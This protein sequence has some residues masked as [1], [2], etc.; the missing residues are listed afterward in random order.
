MKNIL[1]F[2]HKLSG[3][4]AEKTVVNLVEYINHNYDNIHAY[5]GVVYDDKVIHEKMDCVYVLKSHTT[6]EMSKLRKLPVVLSQAVQ[7]R[8][9]KKQLKIDVCISFLPG[10]DFLN[11]L[12]K[13]KEKIIVSVRNKES[14][15]V[16]N[17]LKKWYIQFCYARSNKIIAISAGVQQDIEE[18]FSAPK[19]K[20]KVIYNP[21]PVKV[22][23]GEL[24]EKY[25]KLLHTKQIVISAGRLTEQK[26]QK[27]LIRAFKTVADINPK[28]HLVILGEGEL[29]TELEQEIRRLQLEERIT[30]MGFVYNP[31]DYVKEAEIFVFAS[32]VEGLG[33]V[34]LETLREGVPVISTDCDF[35]PREILAPGTDFTKK[36]QEIEEA[37]Y[38]ILVPVI[39]EQES[40]TSKLSNAICSLLNDEKKRETYRVKALERASDFEIEQIVKEWVDVIENL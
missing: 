4:G 16:K 38:G 17:I 32:I 34:L 36:T 15:F 37:E 7:L 33:N 12:S 31:M 13:R 28:A 5:I 26:G 22:M 3:G 20:V 18:Y 35:G 30:L 10:S 40:D 21:I 24:D 39:T 27:Y 14:F 2:T 9:L 25:Q 19:G 23:Q 8:R 1:F 11:V 6:P 29:R